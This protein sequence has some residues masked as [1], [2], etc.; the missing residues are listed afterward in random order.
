MKLCTEEGVCAF[1]VYGMCDRLKFT[2]FDQGLFSFS[3]L[4]QERYKTLKRTDEPKYRE[5]ERGGVRGE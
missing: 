5:R 4:M 2:L 1:I 3:V